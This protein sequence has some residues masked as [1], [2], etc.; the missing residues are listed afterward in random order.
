MWE[1]GALKVA[2]GRVTEGVDELDVSGVILV[3]QAYRT[4]N[5]QK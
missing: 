4:K 2:S 5:E 1:L 3:G